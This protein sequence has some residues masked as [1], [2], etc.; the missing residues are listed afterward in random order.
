MDNSPIHDEATYDPQTGTLASED[1]GLN[2]LLALDAE[3]LALIAQKLGRAEAES[4]L[5]TAEL[6]RVKIREELWDRDR[7]IFANRL[8]SGRFVRSVGPTSFYPMIAGAVTPDQIASLL[9]HLDDPKKF[10]GVF[11]VFVAK[12]TPSGSD[13]AYATYLGG[14]GATCVVT[15]L[16]SY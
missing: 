7:C 14:S 11:D 3:M 16:G 8:R 2:S 4:F 15:I 6:L 12:L 10:G 9:A 13:L 5:T 1:V